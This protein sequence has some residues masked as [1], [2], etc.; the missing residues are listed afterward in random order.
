MIFLNIA[1]VILANQTVSSLDKFF[2]KNGVVLKSQELEILNLYI[3]KNQDL[4]TLK[5]FSSFL[6]SNQLDLDLSTK[7]KIYQVLKRFI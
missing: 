4:I 7:D 2:K 6:Y 1:K 3:K 5:N